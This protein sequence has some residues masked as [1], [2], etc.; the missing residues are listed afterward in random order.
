MSRPFSHKD[1]AYQNMS[2]LRREPAIQCWQLGD[3]WRLL[4]SAANRSGVAALSRANAEAE[5]NGRRQTAGNYEEIFH[6]Y[7]SFAIT[8]SCVSEYNGMRNENEK[9]KISVL[10][11][12][13]PAVCSGLPAVQA[14]ILANIL[15]HRKANLPAPFFGTVISIHLERRERKY[16]C[17]T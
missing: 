17:V 12:L 13:P 14:T 2:R 9:W 1:Q 8:D 11:S 5:G 7:F 16:L 10:I 3:A 6:F 4:L 15:T